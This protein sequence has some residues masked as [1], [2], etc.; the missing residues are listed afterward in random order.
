M[1]AIIVNPSWRP[2]CGVPLVERLTR[3]LRDAGVDTVEVWPDETEAG[4]AGEP[5]PETSAS[6]RR[7][8]GERVARDLVYIDGRHYLDPRLV[9]AVVSRPGTYLCVDDAADGA[10]PVDVEAEAVVGVGGDGE[11]SWT[12]IARVDRPVD[13]GADPVP[14]LGRLAAAGGVGRLSVDSLDTY[15]PKLRRSVPLHWSLL[16]G[17]GDVRAAEYAVLDASRKNPSDLLATL[18][19]DPVENWVVVRLAN[20]P[21]T[22]NQVSLAVNVL[23][24]TATALFAIGALLPASLLTFAVGLMDG[25]DGKLARVTGRTTRV[26]ST[27]HSFD[28]LF[29]FS[30]LVALGFAL[31]RRLGPRPLLL[32]AVAVTLVAFYRDIY[33]RFGDV[34]GVSLDVYGDFEE[35]FRRL[36]GRRNL[37]NVH[38]LVFV[39]LGAPVLAL[40]TITAHALLT[41]AVYAGRALYWL[42]R[43]DRED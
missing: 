28:L 32:A 7:D 42:R 35:R 8:G 17:E 37:Y 18:V 24:Y 21:V 25:F 5:R 20:T 13:V 43:L 12:G 16:D 6:L 2:V 14:F 11:R 36:A 23:A 19:H 22:P 15:V 27:E 3:S 10:V 39:L 30:W 41:A 29:E 40:Y 9:D 33:G 34:T 1:D 26:G 4:S 38:I 31:S